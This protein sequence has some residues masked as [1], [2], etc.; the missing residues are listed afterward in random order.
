MKCLGMN[1]NMSQLLAVTG[2][3]E[4]MMFQALGCCVCGNTFNPY[5]VHPYT[6]VRWGLLLSLFMDEKTRKSRRQGE[7]GELGRMAVDPMF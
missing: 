6:L 4:L 3:E 5:S 2:V 1:Q 7:E